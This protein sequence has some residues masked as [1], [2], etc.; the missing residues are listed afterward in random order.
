MRDEIL[1]GLN[2][3]LSRGDSLEKAKQAL[4]MAGY[5]QQEI[6]EAA[7]QINMGTVGNIPEQKNESITYKPLPTNP[8]QKIVQKDET[9]PT[10]QP[11]E[12][13][14]LPKMVL[15]LSIIAGI[16]ILGLSF[17]ILFGEKILAA[18]FG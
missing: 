7:N 8:E 11:A 5:N 10:D 9:I 6:D 1:T 14:K 2:N 12:K 15:V 4:A 13:K 3:A 17:F 18:L 16:L